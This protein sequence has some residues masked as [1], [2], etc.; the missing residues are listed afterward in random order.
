MVRILLPSHK[1]DS[2]QHSD[3]GQ[4]ATLRLKAAFREG[5]GHIPY[6][7][8]VFSALAASLFPILMPAPQPCIKQ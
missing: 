8:S 1:L 4:P 3:D 6:A 7:C 2:L 5:R